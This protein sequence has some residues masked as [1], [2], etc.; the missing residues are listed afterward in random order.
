M[1]AAQFIVELGA[2]AWREARPWRR[3]K[4]ARNKRRARLGKPLL[5]LNEGDFDVLPQGKATYTGIGITVASPFI[6]IA[7]NA[8]SPVLENAIINIGMAPAMCEQA[9][10]N[11]VSAGMLAVTLVT[12]AI[13]AIGAY[14]AKWGRARAEKRFQ[15]ELEQAKQPAQQ[16]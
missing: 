6:S 11:C 12:G 5:P 14:V 13:T 7:V 9:D 1:K 8:I 3:L 15:A 2:A 4:I 16:Q 10:P